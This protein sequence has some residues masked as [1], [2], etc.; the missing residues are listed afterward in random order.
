MG[1]L[2]DFYASRIYPGLSAALSW[3]A[4]PF[5]FSLTETVAAVFLAGTLWL[6]VRLIARPGRGKTVLRLAGWVAG[7]VIWFYAGWGLNYFRSSLYARTGMPAMPFEEAEFQEFLDVFAEALNE[8]RCETVQIDPMQLEDEIRTAYAALAPEYGLCRPRAWQHPKRPLFNRL[9]SAVGV[10][11]FIGP[12]FD[13][14]HVNRDTPPLEYPF[15]FAHE[16]AHVLGVSSEAEANFWAFQVCRASDHPSVRYSAWL[17]L[18]TYSASNIRSLLEEDAF[19]AWRARLRPE[20]AEDLAA[21]HDHWQALRRPWLSK[22]QHRFYD[23]FL[24][25]NRIPEGTKNYAQVLRMVL[26]F[27]DFHEDFHEHD[28]GEEG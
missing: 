24:R 21:V 27:S 12:A 4:A 1:L 15:V 6:L 26:T 23:L 22:V 16:Y 9:Y 14:M 28:H 19:Q 8:N 3:L 7:A 25:S 20:V 17:M 18:L 10:L 5:P 2:G 11:G 13:E